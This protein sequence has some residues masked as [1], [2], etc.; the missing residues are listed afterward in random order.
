MKSKA[1]VWQKKGKVWSWATKG[2]PTPRQIGRLTVGQN[3][4]STRLLWDSDL[5]KAALAISSKRKSANYR[6]NFSSERAPDITK[7]VTV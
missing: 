1:V 2:C 7:S 4:N 6:P 3:I 5:R